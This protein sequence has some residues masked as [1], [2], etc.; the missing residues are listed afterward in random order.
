MIWCVYHFCREYFSALRRTP[1]RDTTVCNV[2]HSTVKIWWVKDECFC[3]LYYV[4][5][6]TTLCPISKRSGRLES[7]E[8][9]AE[10]PLPHPP[11]ELPTLNTPWQQESLGKK[12]KISPPLENPRLIILKIILHPILWLYC[13]VHGADCKCV[14]VVTDWYPIVDCF[15]WQRTSTTTPSTAILRRL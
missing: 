10:G 5:G 15:R 9:S 14:V 12:T 2:A 6:E 11:K 1:N 3:F 7:R 4:T 13:N 8:G